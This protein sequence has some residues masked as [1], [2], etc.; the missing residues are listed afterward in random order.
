MRMCTV[1]E[2]IQLY[3]NNDCLSIIIVCKDIWIAVPGLT[4]G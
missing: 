1:E 3:N 2:K 4:R